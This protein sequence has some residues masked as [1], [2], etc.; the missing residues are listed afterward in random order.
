MSDAESPLKFWSIFPKVM[1]KPRQ[2]A[3]RRRTKGVGILGRNFGYLLEVYIKS[4]PCLLRAAWKG[5]RQRNQ[6]LIGH[7]WYYR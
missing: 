4:L 5:V 3:P 7:G 6:G 1:P 2:R